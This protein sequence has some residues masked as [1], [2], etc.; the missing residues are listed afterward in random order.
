MF[1][2]LHAQALPLSLRPGRDHA[3]TWQLHTTAWDRRAF[4]RRPY[5]GRPLT[6]CCP[7]AHCHFA[8]GHNFPTPHPSRWPSI[9]ALKDWTVGIT[10]V[11]LVLPIPTIN[12]SVNLPAS[13]RTGRRS[14]SDVGGE[15]ASHC[16]RE[17]G[18]GQTHPFPTANL[19]R[20]QV[21]LAAKRTS[22]V[23]F[24]SRPPATP[25]SRAI[26]RWA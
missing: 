9:G 2:Y 26:G 20:T 17:G 8:A 22:S 21:S 1:R 12:S 11:K 18:E 13:P 7:H 24:A 14:T 6:S 5:T 19:K 4:P 3:D 23:V 10:I 25:S 15:L 16:S